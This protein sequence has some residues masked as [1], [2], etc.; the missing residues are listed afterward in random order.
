MCIDELALDFDAVYPA[1]WPAR[2]V[3][4]ISKD[5]D[6]A[7]IEIDQMLTDLTEQAPSAWTED[8]LRSHPHWEA[9]RR[10]AHHALALMPVE[11]WNAAP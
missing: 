10:L 7:L 6:S 2:D 5:L 4:W 1:A 8:A 11:P 3:G 9:I